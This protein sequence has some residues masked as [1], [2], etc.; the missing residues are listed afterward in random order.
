[1]TKDQIHFP[2]PSDE[3]RMTNF[4]WTPVRYRNV[5]GILKKSWLGK[6]EQSGK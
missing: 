5:I 6:F 4:V 1:M 2:R 3:R